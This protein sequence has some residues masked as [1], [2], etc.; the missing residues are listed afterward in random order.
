MEKR[1]PAQ[2]LIDWLQGITMNVKIME[3]LIQEHEEGNKG[4]EEYEQRFNDQSWN[5][6]NNLKK[7][8]PLTESLIQSGYEKFQTSPKDSQSE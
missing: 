2:Q 6:A 4:Q 7:I 3:L 1:T 8:K 5:L